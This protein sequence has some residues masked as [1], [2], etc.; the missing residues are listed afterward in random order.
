[1]KKLVLIILVIQVL[2]SCQQTTSLGEEEKE[3]IVGEVT[4]TLNNYCRDVR[5]S[6]LTAE[7]EYLDNS[8]EFFWVP[9]G[10]TGS[11]GYDSIAAILKRNAPKFKSVD[12]AFETLMIT[13]LSS[14]FA[15]Y[16]GRLNSRI[17]DS[18]NK[19]MTMKLVETGVL[20]KRPGGWKLLSG[21]T[22]VLDR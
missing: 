2:F 18:S 7:F 5:K 21:Q 12:N 3:N 17:V 22:S 9:P 6:G 4:S 20:V 10:Y 8:P 19:L 15:T 11:L 14:E 1:M 13:P 16:T